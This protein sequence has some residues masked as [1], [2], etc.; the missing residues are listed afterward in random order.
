MRY[1]FIEKHRSAYAV[2]RM[3]RVLGVTRSGY[4]AWRRRGM[5]RRDIYDQVLLGHIRES[6]KQSRGCYGSP[7]I[8]QDLRDWGYWCGRKR[9]V[10]L[11]RQ[12]GLYAKTRRRFRVTTQSKH[13]FPVA[14]NILGRNFTAT[15]PNRVWVSDIT[16]IWT[17]EGWSYLCV[18]LDIFNRQVVGWSLSARL[19]ADLALSALRKAVFVRRP[20]AGLIVHSDQG[21]QYASE[22]FR[23]ELER[24]GFEQSMSRKGDCYDNAVME[25]FFGTLKRELVYHETYRTRAEARLSV[26]QYIEGF[27]NRRRRHSS[28]GYLSP[29]EFEQAA[30]A[31]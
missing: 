20:P 31:A 7:R 28:L 6:Y 10:R 4:Y 13:G 23:A 30:L 22:E 17:R 16:Y 26:F 18:V 3:C 9:V 14:A 11:M 24:Q 15:A 27:Y 8:W 12:E 29:L 19:T 25:S 5:S 1:R 2:E 21:V